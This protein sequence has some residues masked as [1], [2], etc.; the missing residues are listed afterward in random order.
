MVQSK[1]ILI[2]AVL[3]VASCLMQCSGQ[4]T[5]ST[6]WR[7]GGKRA[8]QSQEIRAALKSASALYKLLVNQIRI[9]AETENC[10]TAGQDFGPLQ[11]LNDNRK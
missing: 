9:L 4:V 8:F 10:Q 2:G 1:W 11:L 5:F 7:P 6:D 3:L